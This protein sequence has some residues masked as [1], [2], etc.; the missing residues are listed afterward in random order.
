MI[1]N[2]TLRPCRRCHVQTL[3]GGDG[4][5]WASVGKDAGSVLHAAGDFTELVQGVAK[6]H[7]H[8]RELAEIVADDVFVGHADSFGAQRGDADVDRVFQR[9]K[10]VGRD[11][12]GR[13]IVEADF[14]RATAAS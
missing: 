5:Q 10:A 13:C 9:R 1:S 7:F 12:R 4:S 14:G 6:G 8:L 2:T 11:Q 3:W